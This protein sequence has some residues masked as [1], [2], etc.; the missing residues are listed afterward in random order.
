MNFELLTFK[1]FNMKRSYILV[2]ALSIAGFFSASAQQTSIE[3]GSVLEIVKP[4]GNFKHIKVPRSNFIIKQT[5]I[6]NLNSIDGN[7][8]VVT[9]ISDKKGQ[10][11]ITFNRKDGRKFFNN[12]KSLSAIWPAALESGELRLV[13]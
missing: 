11:M 13:E 4:N 9:S 3:P 2:I 6:A 7:R 10:K 1:S 5:G 12:Y 8:V